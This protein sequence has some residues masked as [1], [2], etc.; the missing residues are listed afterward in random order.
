[1]SPR[2]QP[3]KALVQVG[4]VA[5]CDLVAATEVLYDTF[6]IRCG[7][8]IQGNHVATCNGRWYIGGPRRGRDCFCFEI[9]RLHQVRPGDGA[10]GELVDRR[11]D[12]YAERVAS[13]ELERQACGGPIR[14]R[15]RYVQ[16]RQ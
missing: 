9:E 16:K 8:L 3:W 14:V 13:A 1:M 11:S 4:S 10:A 5:A 12:R 7:Q 6:C 15:P 2:R